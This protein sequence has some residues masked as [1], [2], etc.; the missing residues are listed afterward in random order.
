MAGEDGRCLAKGIQWKMGCGAKVRFWEDGWRVD[1]VPLKQ[2]Y[3][4]LFTISKQ[5][6]QSIQCMGTLSDVGWE[7]DLKWRRE[8]F[9]SE[10]DMAVRFLEDL[11]GTNIHPKRQ[12]KWIWKE[13][14]SGMYTARNGYSLLMAD[15]INENQDGFSRSCGRSRSLV[16]LPSLC[17]DLSGTDYPLKPIC[18]GGMWKFM[19]LHAHFAKIRKRMQ[20]TS[21]LVAARSCHFGGNHY[22]G[23]IPQPHFQRTPVCT[24]SSKCFEMEKTLAIKNGNAGGLP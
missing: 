10:L 14:V 22:R 23:Q 20:H 8:L 7:W 15:Q 6:N 9:D 1:G 5:Q 11:Q 17:G 12:D 19:I 4:T 3:P 18:A 21:F 16:K 13:D 2:K 24:S